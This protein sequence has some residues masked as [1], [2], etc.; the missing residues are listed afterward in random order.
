LLRRSHAQNAKQPAISPQA[1]TTYQ[2]NVFT[3]MPPKKA[4]ERSPLDRSDAFLISV[5]RSRHSL[6]G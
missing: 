2:Q 6:G 4:S 3:S 1:A 5:G